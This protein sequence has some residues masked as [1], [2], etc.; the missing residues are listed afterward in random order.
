MVY[1]AKFSSDYA[2]EFDVYGFTIFDTEDEFNKAVSEFYRGYKE[3]FGTE[4]VEWY[5]GTNEFIYF[6]TEEDIK[7]AYTLI[8]IS[9][10][11]ADFLISQFGDSW[12]NLP[13]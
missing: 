6:P 11:H 1:L 8:K 2:D 13:V 10:E 3:D 9:G 12:G 4:D 7:K 5:F